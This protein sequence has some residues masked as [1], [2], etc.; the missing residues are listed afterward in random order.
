M[1]R[2][3]CNPYLPMNEYIPDGEP[4]IFG[5]RLYIFGSHDAAGGDK[6]CPLDYVVWSAPMDDLS[7]W[8]CH[9]EIYTRNQDPNNVNGDLYLYAPDVV[10]GNDGKY[11]LYYCMG[12][13]PQI[14]VA[15]S[16]QPAGKYKYL[17]KV[18]YPNGLPYEDN[19]PFDPAIIND[20]GR[21]YLY[22]G[23]TP[24]FPIHG[25]IP[26]E[27][28][29]CSC[30]E[31]EDDM[32]TVKGVRNMVIPSREHAKNTTF[33]GNA[34]FEAPSIR[35]IKNQYYLVYASEKAHTLCYAISSKPNQDF[36]YGG[37][38]IS[39]GDV[40]LNGRSEEHAVWPTANNHGG[41]IEINHELYIFYHRHTH[42]T[43]FSRQGC[44]EKINLN[45]NGFIEQVEMTSMG[46]SKEPLAAKG[47]YQ[48]AIACNLW[49][50]D[51]AQSPKF[52]KVNLDVPSVISYE[53]EQIIT[54][55]DHES[56]VGYKY[57][58]FF[59]RGRIGVMYRGNG[60]GK[61]SISYILGGPIIA[62]ILFQYSDQ[63][64]TG[65]SDFEIYG[66]QAIYFQY[67]GSGIFDLRTIFFKG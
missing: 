61:L 41:I 34:Y 54:H 18:Q 22:Y 57:F 16:D 9:G 7:N 62:E 64:T 17:G 46:M 32:L 59:G 43:M 67:Q 45:K 56:V 55:I 4:H 39:N 25:K 35:K 47:E 23:F 33:E 13:I 36:V 28:D 15:V 44:V 66:R 38:I 31:L 1:N 63:W 6:F 2:K 53:N 10:Q 40:G 27:C 24:P 14:S 30:I 12:L 42:G 65:W 58:E 48:A 8:Y 11:Y 5:D 50:K 37:A 51:G 21:F 52:G 26:I 60:K 19:M 29:G 20:E 3:L 49:N